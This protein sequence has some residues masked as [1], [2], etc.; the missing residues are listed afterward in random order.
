MK[1][2]AFDY[3]APD[4][5]EAAVMLLSA[6]DNARVLA[7]GQ[8]L[9]PMMNFRYVLPDTII[10][11]NNIENLDHVSVSHDVI[12]IGALT[13]QRSLEFSAD[14]ARLCPLLSE[15]VGHIGHRQTRNRG[16]VGGSLAHADPA[17]ELPTIAMALDG[18]I[19]A[20]SSRGRRDIHINDFLL[21][22][23]TTALMP[24][25]LLCGVRLPLW[26]Q[27]HGAAFVEIARRR[28]DFA[29]VSAA[30]LIL[31][32]DNG[33]VVRISLTLAGIGA[34]PQRVTEAEEF[35]LGQILTPARLSEVAAIAGRLDAIGDIHAS[36]AYRQHLASVLVTKAL[37]T[38]LLRAQGNTW[39]PTQ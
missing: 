29:I 17:A 37:T 14:I 33:A 21:G 8:S 34:A 7:G 13:R 16:T 22:F 28:G 15:A 23:M 30:A 3:H 12:E 25:E 1:P 20:Q 38:A 5:V 35:L 24:D 26:P 32:D 27:G 19:V 2:P 31:L 18:V 39:T 10:D 4:N 6:H 9:M 11:I 36:P